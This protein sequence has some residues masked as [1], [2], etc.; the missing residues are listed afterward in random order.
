MPYDQERIY[1]GRVKAKQIMD[2]GAKMVIA[3]CHNCRDQIMKSLTKEFGLDIETK[4]LWELVADSLVVE[5]WSEEEI[6]EA[7]AL[8]DAQYERDG[9]DLEEEEY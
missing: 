3:P 8:R 2:T 6:K 7:H 1:Y 9:V 4:Y 5:P